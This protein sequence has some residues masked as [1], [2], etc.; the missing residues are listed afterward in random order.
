MPAAPRPDRCTPNEYEGMQP[1]PFICRIHNVTPGM[2]TAAHES[3]LQTQFQL[4]IQGSL[5]PPASFK[6]CS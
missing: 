1:D 6:V 4:D 5:G 3:A 2:H